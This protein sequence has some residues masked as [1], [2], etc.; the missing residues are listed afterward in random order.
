MNTLDCLYEGKAKSLYRTDDSDL[1]LALYRDDI[2]A[3]NAEKKTQ[4]TYKGIINNHISAYLME[5]L[6]QHHVPTHFVSL[7]SENSSIIRHLTMLPIEVVIRNVAAGSI[8]RRLGLTEGEKMS[9]PLLEFFLKDDDLGD[10]LI[11]K[12]HIL[13][14]KWATEAQLDEMARLAKE[15]NT[16]MQNKFDQC[17]IELVDFKVEFGV[18]KDG[19]IT[20]GDELSPDSFRLWDKSS[21]DSLDKDR[22]RK[23]QG[24]VVASYRIVADRLG[25]KI[26]S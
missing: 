6:H 1:L 13:M 14:F 21:G 19:K 17:G 2:T 23:D 11:T 18:D 22:F 25:I 16:V 5:L 8:C 10:P 3:F 15:I 9:Y 26:P 24:D 4:L 20:L 12:E 7:E